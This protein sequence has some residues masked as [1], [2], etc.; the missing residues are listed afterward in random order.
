DDI[1]DKDKEEMMAGGAISE[2]SDGGASGNTVRIVEPR[3]GIGLEYEPE[4]SRK[5]SRIDG[6]T[7]RQANDG[8]ANL[9]PALI[10][11]LNTEEFTPAPRE[12]FKHHLDD[13]HVGDE[14]TLSPLGQEPKH[15]GL[16][17][18]GKSS[19]II[20]QTK[21]MWEEFL[22]NSTHSIKRV[23]SSP[24]GVNKSYLILFLAA[25]VYAD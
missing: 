4:T 21:R 24:M 5:F 25:K 17:Y 19:F 10:K 22:T 1:E 12:E 18:Q 9:P 14:I 11:L 3:K 2:Y 16:G 23:L 13:K 7:E 20:E 6:W 15:Y 8:P